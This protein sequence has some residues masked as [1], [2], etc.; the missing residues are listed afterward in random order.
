MG[1]MG[2]PASNCDEGAKSAGPNSAEI[3]F[4][5]ARNS[6]AMYASPLMPEHEPETVAVPAAVCRTS[7]DHSALK[8]T[9]L[10][11]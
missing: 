11:A 3:L 5:C 8:G 1:K 2:K 6:T 10:L 7:W 4:Y 9:M